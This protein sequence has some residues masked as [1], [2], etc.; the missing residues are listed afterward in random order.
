MFRC[1]AL[2]MQFLIFFY[3]S[4]VLTSSVSESHCCIWITVP[5]ECIRDLMMPLRNKQQ[6]FIPVAVPPSHAPPKDFV[7]PYAIPSDTDVYKIGNASLKSLDIV[8][9]QLQELLP[10][11]I[12]YDFQD[13]TDADTML[14]A[15][16]AEASSFNDAIGIVQCSLDR[17]LSYIKGQLP[18][19]AGI[20]Q[21]LSLF[22]SNSVPSEWAK[23]FGLVS[24]QTTNLGLITLL[25]LLQKR[26][27]F[28]TKCLNDGIVP[29][30]M[31]PCMLSRPSVVAALLQQRQRTEE[32]QVFASQV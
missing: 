22:M 12:Q 14:L 18:L 29:H 27:L 3:Y 20:C 7:V 26:S 10:E 1:V 28:L 16:V 23:M 30:I 4:Q 32:H 24:P 21:L 2:S 15:M 25:Q 13:K 6:R 17:C 9:R 11:P 19:V 31:D 8:V 5:I